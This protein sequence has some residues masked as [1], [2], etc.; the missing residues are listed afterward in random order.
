MSLLSG[1]KGDIG[2]CGTELGGSF[3][4]AVVAAGGGGG[5]KGEV[6]D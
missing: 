5:D 4:S 3:A 2:D 1:V 6:D